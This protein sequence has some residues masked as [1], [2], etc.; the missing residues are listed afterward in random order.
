MATT[1]DERGQVSRRRLS[2]LG[3]SEL[4]LASV[5]VDWEIV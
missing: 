2:M 3:I 1:A 4:S 5:V